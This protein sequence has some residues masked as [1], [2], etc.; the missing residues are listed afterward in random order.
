MGRHLWVIAWSGTT[1]GV[2]LFSSLFF[3]KIFPAIMP[4]IMIAGTVE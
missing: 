1:T 4:K 2:E 3:C